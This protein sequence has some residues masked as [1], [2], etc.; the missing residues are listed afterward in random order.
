MSGLTKALAAEL[1]GTFASLFLSAGAAMI[2]A[3]RRTG[4]VAAVVRANDHLVLDHCG[5]ARGDGGQR[6]NEQQSYHPI[7]PSPVLAYK[8]PHFTPAKFCSVIR[9]SAWHAQTFVIVPALIVLDP[10]VQK[11]PIPAC[12]CSVQ[13]SD[14]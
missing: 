13:R 14:Q 9:G 8:D 10:Q 12:K 7:T 6:T 2:C 4:R 11:G 5:V 1:I 3:T